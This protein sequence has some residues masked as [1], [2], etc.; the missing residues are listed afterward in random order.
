MSDE[1]VDNILT[2]YRLR[3]NIDKFSNLAKPQEIESNDYNL[4]IPRY[5]D[6]FEP[7]PII[8]MQELL[9]SLIQTEREIQ[10]TEL[11]LLNFMRQL[12]GTTPE[13]QRLHEESVTKFERLIENRQEFYKQ[14]EL[15]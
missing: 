14:M 9:D 5:V 2:A 4:N 8:P 1:H 13:Q 15:F 3:R 11:E 6:T 10:T 7:E 12:V